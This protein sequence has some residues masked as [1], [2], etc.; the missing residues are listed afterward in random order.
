MGEGY[1]QNLAEILRDIS[2]TNKGSLKEL[3]ESAVANLIARRE[4]Q[5]LKE[6]EK[7]IPI[8]MSTATKP[9]ISTGGLQTPSE[10][11]AVEHH[12]DEDEDEDED[13]DA[14]EDE[15]E[16]GDEDEYEESYSRESDE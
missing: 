4:Y 7:Q 8:L 11:G 12:S 10:Y 2:D 15:D 9:I 1:I 6:T 5:R 13:E 3:H 14:D 16:D